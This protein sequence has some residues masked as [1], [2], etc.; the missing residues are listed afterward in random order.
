MGVIESSS[1]EISSSGDENER[2]YLGSQRN[3]RPRRSSW[4]CRCLSVQ[5]SLTQSHSRATNE[6]IAA[7]REATGPHPQGCHGLDPLPSCPGPK[8][9]SNPQFSRDYQVKDLMHIC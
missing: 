9:K 2:P 4:R 6:L 1:E 7:L 3:P 5:E 8:S